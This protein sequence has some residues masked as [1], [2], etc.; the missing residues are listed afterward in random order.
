M[1]IKYTLLI[2]NKRPLD[3]SYNLYGLWRNYANAK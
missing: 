2:L 1:G 3:V